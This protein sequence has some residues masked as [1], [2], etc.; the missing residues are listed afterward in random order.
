MGPYV[1]W[2]PHYKKE[3]AERTARFFLKDW[4]LSQDD[5]FSKPVNEAECFEITCFPDTSRDINL[6]KK[7]VSS[8]KRACGPLTRLQPIG[9]HMDGKPESCVYGSDASYK[10]KIAFQT[11]SGNYNQIHGLYASTLVKKA[12]LFLSNGIEEVIYTPRSWFWM[13]SARQRMITA[14]HFR[15]IKGSL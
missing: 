6:I 4:K 10:A 13:N 12:P 11:V 5:C 7:A 3:D 14:P 2:E 8:F 9:I 15:P 1:H